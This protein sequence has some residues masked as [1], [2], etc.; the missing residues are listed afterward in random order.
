ME[1]DLTVTIPFGDYA[2]GDRIT[3]PKAVAEHVDSGYVVKVP[4]QAAKPAK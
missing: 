1:F 4:K 2:V 3:D